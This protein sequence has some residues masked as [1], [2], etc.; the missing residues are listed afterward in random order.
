M[1]NIDEEKLIEQLQEEIQYCITCQPYDDGD[2]VWILGEETEL[3]ELFDTFKVPESLR[4]EIAENLQCPNCGCQFERGAQYGRKS[5]GEK[6]YE[7]LIDKKQKEWGKKYVQV[8]DDFMSFIEKYPYLGAKHSLGKKIVELMPKFPSRNIKTG[9]W[10]RARKISDG[11]KFTHTDMTAPNPEKVQVGE[12]R[13]NHFG[14]SHFYL[15]NTEIGAAIEMLAGT[16]EKLVWIQS[17]AIHNA[18]NI[19][20]VRVGHFH[21]PDPDAPIVAT[22]LIYFSNVLNSAVERSKYWKPE[23]FV[24]RFVADAAKQAGFNGILYTSNHH[25][26]DNL[27]IFDETKIEYEFK[28]EPYVFTLEDES[29]EFKRDFRIIDFDDEDEESFP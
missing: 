27:V 12:G 29:E 5:D 28:G 10:F 13:F 25:Y 2:V 4:D 6:L 22:G 8:L 18:T 20:D 21:E 16:D 1:K 14:Q 19:L 7:K 3:E 24:P 23:Y 15:A 9:N 26:F 17:I 11:R